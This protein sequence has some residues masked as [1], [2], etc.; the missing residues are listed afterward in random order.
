MFSPYS[1]AAALVMLLAGAAGRTREEIARTL[2]H[3]GEGDG[4]LDA[5]RRI[6]D[7]L[8]SRRGVDLLVA[9]GLWC[10]AG[11]DL[12]RA[13][14]EDLVREL[15]VRIESVDFV[16]APGDAANAVNGW[17]RKWTRDK[18]DH[19]LSR[20]DISAL[21]RVVLANAVYFKGDWRFRF[22]EASTR[23]ERFH[24]HDGSSA[25]VPT[26]HQKTDLAYARR[27]GFHCL[28][29][30]YGVDYTR[31]L[32]LLPERRG[33]QALRDAF[34]VETLDDAERS[35]ESR[36]IVLS[37]PR[38]RF[39]SSFE[40]RQALSRLGVSTAFGSEADFSRISAE[41][42]FR[43]DQMRHTTFVDVTESG[44]EAAAVT[45]L[46]VVAAAPRWKL[47]EK[48]L[49]IRVDRPFAF[50]IYDSATGAA[51]FAGRV[52]DPRRD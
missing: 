5:F 22:P 34:E 26:M 42:G 6:R 28:S 27:R 3:G 36:K 40:L 15:A 18:I 29:L 14:V 24:L 31:M 9:N 17:V 2:G 49:V 12:D 30:P 19:V 48:P 1:I 4:L 43:V 16:G 37:M 47:P 38:F 7:Q 50:L 51:L 11:Y 35:M 20:S 33:V 13:F 46:S 41:P 32:V 45:A 25:E 23:P 8:E 10:Q 39:R 21:T 44:T 52:M